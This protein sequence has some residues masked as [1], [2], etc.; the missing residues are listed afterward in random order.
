MTHDDKYLITSG[1]EG[2]LNII[3]MEN[4]DSVK[5][6]GEIDGK[7]RITEILVSEDISCFTSKGA[8]CTT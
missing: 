8:F 3:D 1:T 5:Q 6:F 2:T 7:N 4:L